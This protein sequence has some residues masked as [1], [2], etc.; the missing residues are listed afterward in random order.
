MGLALSDESVKLA[1]LTMSNKN[2]L[3][4]YDNMTITEDNIIFTNEDK[5][6]LNFYPDI[7][8]KCLELIK[9]SKNKHH[10]IIIFYYQRTIFG[11]RT[12]INEV[13]TDYMSKV[14]TA[15]YSLVLN[16]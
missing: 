1:T 13:E 14:V 7:K 12:I 4:R 3:Y 10:E 2:K 8:R 15:E 9:D 11:I 16:W 6:S 5:I